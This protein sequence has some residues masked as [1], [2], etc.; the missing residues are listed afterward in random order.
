MMLPALV[1]ALLGT[2]FGHANPI[3]HVPGAAL[4]LPAV[5]FRLG[6]REPTP[7]VAFRSGFFC[8]AAAYS[9]SLYWVF[10]PVHVHG[11][12]HWL[13]ALPCPILL[14][15]YLG[16]YGGAFS[17]LIR[18]AHPVHS[19]LLLGLGAGLLWGGV[20]LAQGTLFTGFSWLTLPAA[21]APWPVTIQGLAVVGEYG[22]SAILVTAVAWLVLA[23][24][25][26]AFMIRGLT[27]GLALFLV[28]IGLGALHLNRPLPEGTPLRVTLVQGNVDQTVKWEP[29][30]QEATVRAYLDLTTRELGFKP[31]LVVWPETAMPFYLQEDS[32]LARQVRDFVRS[33]QQLALL[34][35]APRYAVDLSTGAIQYANSAF[36]LGPNGKTVGIYDKE[37]LVPFG[38]YVPLGGMLPFIRRLAHSEGDFSP[39][40]DPAPL[41]WEHLALGMLICYEAIFSGLSQ[42][43]VRAGANLLVNIS[44]DAWFGRSSAPR[45]HLYQAV[46]RSVEQ[47]R[48]LV[49]S[50]NTGVTAIIDPRGRRLEAGGLFQRLTLSYP[51]VRLLE[52]TTFFHRNAWAIRILL[53]TAIGLYLGA[54]WWMRRRH[55]TPE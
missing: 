4:L 6:L 52:E 47:G 18:W 13:L 33:T 26:K 11:G 27:L 43:R 23:R 42:E 10:I 19:P 54:T 24:E 17:A 44:N 38:E 41:Q 25:S 51:D 12:L 35:G 46:L 29:A 36:L 28:L 45:Q 37:H 9:A 39:G 20:E 8:A 30:Y 55:R 15:M 32:A 2:W 34:T 21:L 50:T 3:A 22:L 53:P 40:N 14:G 49:R 48:F 31:E 1:V 16:L 5:L 7:A